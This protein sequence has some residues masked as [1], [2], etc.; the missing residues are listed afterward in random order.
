MSLQGGTL[1]R[2]PRYR[3][4]GTPDARRL[5]EVV[6][7]N[8]KDRRLVAD[9][10]QEELATR[11]RALNHA[12]TDSTVG[13]V[14]TRDRNVT[15]D[16]LAALALALGALIGELL[17]PAG[18][19]AD[20]DTALDPGAGETK[21]GELRPGRALG[22]RLARSWVWG[23]TRFAVTRSDPTLS[24]RISPAAPPADLVPDTDRPR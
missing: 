22:P 13:D 17:D 19:A 23:F 15:V 10:S 5:N 16:E 3:G 1:P 6:A 2:A 24:W 9:I 20:N 14:E 8:M 7:K 12:W 4:T 11:M 21:R 18:I